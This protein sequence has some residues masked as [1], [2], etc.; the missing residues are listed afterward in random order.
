M[1]PHLSLDP[2]SDVRQLLEFPFMVHALEGGTIEALMAAVTGW[3]MVLRRQ[4]CAGHTLSVMSSPG[5]SGAAL[6]GIPLAAG[7]FASCALA[8]LAIG[9]AGRGAAGR[10]RPRESAIIGTVQVTG[11]ALGF[12]FLSLYNGVLESLETLLFGSF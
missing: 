6:A 9:A 1:N 10:D 7:Y 3:Y 12:L 11:L 8:A 5:A 4:S 2:V